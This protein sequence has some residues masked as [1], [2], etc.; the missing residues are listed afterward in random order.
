MN[1]LSL[2]LFKDEAL[3][4]ILLLV[5]LAFIICFVLY[6]IA[7]KERIKE[8][9]CVLFLTLA[10]S[11][12]SLYA[13][14]NT[15]IPTTTWQ[16]YS[17][18][19]EIIFKLEECDFD[20]VSLF[21]NE[22]DNNSN[23]DTY[24]NGIK[25]I[26][27]YG[28]DDLYEWYEITTFEKGSIYAYNDINGDFS[29]QYVRLVCTNKN[30]SLS[31]IAFKKKGE[32]RLI[33]I[34]VYKDMGDVKYPS[35]LLIDEQD[36]VVIN[37]T[38]LDQSYF[39][40][41]Y[42]VRNANEIAN[43]Q[44]MYASVHPLLG[45]TFI[46]LG[47]KIFG[48][49]PLG[50]RLPGAI[51]GIM[52]VPLFYLIL[53]ELFKDKKWSL[54]GTFLLDIE[55][56]HLTTSRIATLEPFSVFFILLMYYFMIRY[57]NSEIY[58]KKI[59]N[60]LLCGISMGLGVVTKWTACYSAVGLAI[61]LF[62]HLIINHKDIKEVIFTLLW[63][64]LFFIAIPIIIYLL[65]YIPCHVNR[66]GYSIKGVIDQI[67]YMYN[68][69]VN[70]KA[71]HPYQSQWWQ[72]LLDLRPI[73]YYVGSDVNHVYH[74]IACFSNPIITWFGLFSIL[75]TVFD[76]IRNRNKVAYIIVIGYLSALLPWV[77]FVKRCVFAYH[78]YPTSMF[79]LMSIVYVCKK[80]YQKNKYVVITFAILSLLAFIIYLP[81][82]TGFGTFKEYIKLIEIIPS[83]NL[84]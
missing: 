43:G 61:L 20:K 24:Q 82:I 75:Y 16:P 14:G 54:F 4:S 26:S 44:Y 74:T 9:I 66:D 81:P 27:L 5:A 35:S 64:L 10:Y 52:M 46:A 79:M 3:L 49:N 84:G 39:D 18:Y 69:H 32:N 68:Y 56:M 37:P 51:F 15:S 42:H 22:G 60:L 28:S 59:I 31:E 7:K 80:I 45:T 13:L 40:E 1:K 50:W 77:S 83:W 41:I 6:K 48:N 78:F 63:C 53:K 55:F 62:T 72:W 47:I 2:T 73:W 65:A 12:V 36:K 25:G 76:L 30:A 58:K 70:L 29:Y 19:D 67:V 21:Y 71:T 11:I 17:N 33:S 23:L 38:Y 8:I 34:S 57:L